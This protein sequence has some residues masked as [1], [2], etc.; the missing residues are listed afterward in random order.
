MDLYDGHT[1]QKFRFSEG[2]F[3]TLELLVKQLEDVVIILLIVIGSSVAY[4]YFFRVKASE[5]GGFKL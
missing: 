5:P 1:G 4:F 2:N 3:C